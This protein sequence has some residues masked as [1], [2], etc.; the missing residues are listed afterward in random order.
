MLVAG[1]KP[2]L[3]TKDQLSSEDPAH[4]GLGHMVTKPNRHRLARRHQGANQQTG[5]RCTPID[6]FRRVGGHPLSVVSPDRPALPGRIEQLDLI[7]RPCSRQD[8]LP[9]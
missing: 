8:A 1:R 6:Q 7:E 3:V 2:D 9:R 4:R 5:P